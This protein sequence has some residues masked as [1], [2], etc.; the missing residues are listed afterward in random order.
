M[1]TESYKH[2]YIPQFI[3]RNFSLRGDGFVKFYN[4]KKKEITNKPTEEIFYYNNLYR[5]EKN[6][7]ENPIKIEEDLAKFECE[8]A[9]I[10]KKFY[11][12]NEIIISRED[13]EKLKLFFAIMAYRNRKAKKIFSENADPKIVEMYKPY[14]KNENF[15][16]LWKKNLGIAV[17]CR[18]LK[19]V[20]DSN[21][22]IDPF[23]ASLFVMSFGV[24]GTH[25]IVVERRGGEDFILGD[26]YPYFQTALHE[27]G[28]R[29]PLLNYY[30][31]SPTRAII[32]AI[33]DIDVVP[34]K[35]RHINESLFRKPTIMNNG[36]DIK[37]TVKKIYE[38]DVRFI[39][40]LAWKYIKDGAVFIDD[41][42]VKIPD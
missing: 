15:D 9:S 25:L 20:L 37:Y 38:E 24:T 28:S 33:N 8:I 36:K 3:I 13:E 27:D 34:Q 26:S 40:D 17:N 19:E 10:L 41:N 4:M 22:I 12:G 32:I 23:K 6:H 16:D 1:K 2:H 18:S 35:A 21:E 14:L 39:N 29:W 31:I 42:R 11:S 7:P 30:V 5:D